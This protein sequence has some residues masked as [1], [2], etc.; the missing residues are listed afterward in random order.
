MVRVLV[1][2]VDLPSKV[3]KSPVHKKSSL[4]TFHDADISDLPAALGFQRQIE[5]Y[6]ATQTILKKKKK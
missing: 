6:K 1:A 5:K 3:T 2:V 4:T